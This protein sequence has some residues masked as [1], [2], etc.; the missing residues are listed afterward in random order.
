MVVLGST[1]SIGTNTLEI[2]QRYSLPIETLVAGRNIELLNKQIAQFSPK[3]VVVADEQL[4]KSVQHNNVLWGDDGILRAVEESES[5]TVVNA[6]VGFQGLRPT[7]KALQL[8]KK[9]A[10]ANKES[11]VV[12]GSFIDT[13][14]IKPI[15]SEHFGL[16]YL[17]NGRGVKKMT[18]TASGGAF[19]DWDISEIHFANRDDALKHPNWSMGNKITVDSASMVN[20]LFELLEVKW[21]FQPEEIDALIE[22]SSMVHA[23]VEFVDGSTTAHISGTDMKLPIAFAVLDRVNEQ[24]LEPIDILKMGS[25]QFREIEKSRYPLWELKDELMKYPKKG[26]ILNSANDLLVERF[27]KGKIVFGEIATGVFETF[28]KFGDSQP[29]SIDEVFQMDREIRQWLAIRG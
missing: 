28:K 11:L 27:L 20:K 17:L 21:L 14:K 6:L 24:I 29:S 2:A 26:L 8:N 1:G 18:I 9:L 19:R 10:L 5:E 25:L 12:A 23:F 15:D 22:P 16:W 13:S 4:A 7:L 3:T